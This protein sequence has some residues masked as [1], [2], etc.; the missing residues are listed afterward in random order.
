MKGDSGV[1]E[2][3]ALN[4]K[5][6]LVLERSFFP[7]I[8]KTRIRIFKAEI[9]NESTDVSKYEALKDVKYVPVKKKL[10]IDLNDYISLLDQSYSS[11]DN[12]ESMCWG[13][14]LS[15]GK[16][17]LILISDNNFN[18]FQRTQFVILE[19]DF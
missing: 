14:R 16:R 3:L 13:P 11:L 2:A 5:E 9:Q 10:L 17:S 19:T 4:D 1:S 12:I 7:S 18:V 15:N 6:F 8:L